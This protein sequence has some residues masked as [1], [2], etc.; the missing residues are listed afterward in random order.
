MRTKNKTHTVLIKIKEAS[1]GYWRIISSFSFL[2]NLKLFLNQDS[3]LRTNTQKRFI[4][5]IFDF[6][7]RDGAN[8]V[9]GANKFCAR[10]FSIC[11]N[12]QRQPVR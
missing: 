7:M 2:S 1:G 12:R 4:Y 5:F 10:V 9:P 6:K 8:A 3:S 11:E